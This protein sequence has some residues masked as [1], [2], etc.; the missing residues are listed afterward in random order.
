MQFLALL[1]ATP[2]GV[3]SLY[4]VTTGIAFVW[5]GLTIFTYF[6]ILYLNRQIAI[7]LVIKGI[8]KKLKKY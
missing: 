4:T 7:R 5:L 2:F 8:G 3:L 1:A 6:L